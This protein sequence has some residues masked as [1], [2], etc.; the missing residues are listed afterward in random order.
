MVQLAVDLLT[1]I[2][3]YAVPVSGVFYLG[4]MIVFSF[5]DFAFSGGRQWFRRSRY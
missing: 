2:V 5:F 3:A 4:Y 1:Q